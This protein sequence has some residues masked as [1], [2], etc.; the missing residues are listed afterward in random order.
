[1]VAKKLKLE[2]QELMQ[3]LNLYQMPVKGFI[4]FD[5][6]CFP[7]VVLF[8]FWCFFAYFVTSFI[9]VVFFNKIHFIMMPYG[10]LI[11]HGVPK[12]LSSVIALIFQLLHLRVYAEVLLVASVFKLELFKSW[13]RVVN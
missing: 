6:F 10:F 9:D 12:I 11:N 7:W 8:C 1:M 13:R 2:D 5:A 3:H 4:S